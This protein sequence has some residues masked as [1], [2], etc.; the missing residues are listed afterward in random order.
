MF[1]NGC[2][3]CFNFA[4][5]NLALCLHD[6]LFKQGIF[7]LVQPVSVSGFHVIL[8]RVRPSKAMLEQPVS[9]QM[10]EYDSTRTS[11]SNTTFVFDHPVQISRTAHL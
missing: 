7:S 6:Q 1:F 9:V 8:Q 2:C 3:R 4:C 5:I 11:T 10:I